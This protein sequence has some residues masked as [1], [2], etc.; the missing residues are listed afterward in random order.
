LPETPRLLG[1][2]TE[3][4]TVIPTGAP[5]ART[6]LKLGERFGYRMWR[7]GLAPLLLSSYSSGTIWFPGEELSSIDRSP[8]GRGISA[9][10]GDWDRIGIVAFRKPETARFV[11]DHWPLD[12][13][14]AWGS[15]ALWGEVVLHEDGYRAEHARVWSIEDVR[16]CAADVLSRLQALYYETAL[17]R[18]VRQLCGKNG[19]EHERRDT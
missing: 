3:R 15:V 13:P 19:R 14:I 10:P 16:G 9:P 1:Q 4:F 11:F 2:P 6:R 18:G 17:A 8:N 7:I 5:L 12:D